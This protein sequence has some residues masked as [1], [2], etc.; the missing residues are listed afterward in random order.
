M[1]KMFGTKHHT[2]A[3]NAVFYLEV[4]AIVFYLMNDN[5]QYRILPATLFNKR[6]YIL[7]GVRIAH[8]H[9]DISA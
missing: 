4:I 8:T 6:L 7:F 1:E 9:R 3:I 2:N 5:S